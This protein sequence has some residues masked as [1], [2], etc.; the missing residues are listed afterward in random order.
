MLLLIS[1]CSI[2]NSDLRFLFGRLEL[3]TITSVA[4]QDAAKTEQSRLRLANYGITMVKSRN[5]FGSSYHLPYQHIPNVHDPWDP[6]GP[7]A[8]QPLPSLSREKDH[9][10]LQRSMGISINGG[11]LRWMVYIAK[12][13]T[14]M[15]DLGVPP[16]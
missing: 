3:A 14:E 4:R 10:R 1:I 11:I 6:Q 9:H 13:C 12:S 7:R 16:F 8:R 5:M 2:F 15:D